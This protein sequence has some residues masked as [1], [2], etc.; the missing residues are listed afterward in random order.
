MCEQ[1]AVQAVFSGE[2]PLHQ[3]DLTGSQWSENKGDR[4]G[5]WGGPSMMDDTAES[6]G[7]Y[8]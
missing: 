6:S 5:A 7:G 8:C 4:D 2:R 3:P 1:G